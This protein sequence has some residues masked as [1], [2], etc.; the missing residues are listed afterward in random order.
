ML[1]T[2]PVSMN[3]HPSDVTGE[4]KSAIPPDVTGA[5]AEDSGD[6]TTHEAVHRN[7]LPPAKS[8]K[9]SNAIQTWAVFHNRLGM[10][11]WMTFH[12]TFLPIYI[13]IIIIINYY[14]Y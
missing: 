6:L 1:V 10:V 4:P 5:P 7:G 14:Y 3:H 13:I 8:Q 11:A 12:S 9:D 2:I